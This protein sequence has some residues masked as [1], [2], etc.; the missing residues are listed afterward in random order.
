VS[1]VKVIPVKGLT[2]VV[3]S[4]QAVD[5]IK[6]VLHCPFSKKDFILL[7]NDLVEYCWPTGLKNLK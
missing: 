2:V 4:T 5:V 3:S 7:E 6:H 1:K